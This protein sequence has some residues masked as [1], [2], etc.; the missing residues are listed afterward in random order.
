MCFLGCLCA[1]LAESDWA[2]AHILLRDVETGTQT[3]C[4]DLARAP[5]RDQV[6]PLS[7]MTESK[8][9]KTSVAPERKWASLMPLLSRPGP[10]AR[11]KEGFDAKDDN[12]ARL[13]KV[14]VARVTADRSRCVGIDNRRRLVCWWPVRARWAARR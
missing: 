10:F 5:S 6:H 4:G 11:S 12:L 1:D 13:R 3:V 8:E 14:M 9:S 2:R 7:I